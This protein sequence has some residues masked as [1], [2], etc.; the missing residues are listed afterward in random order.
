MN[1]QK[2]LGYAKFDVNIFFT[3]LYSFIK[4]FFE[5]NI[6]EYILLNRLLQQHIR[7]DI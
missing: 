6:F 3:L 1:Q 4:Y 7:Y 2:K 5:I